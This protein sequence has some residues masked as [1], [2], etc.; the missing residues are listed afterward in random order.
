MALSLVALMP[1]LQFFQG[2]RRTVRH[3]K[4]YGQRGPFFE[5][6]SLVSRVPFHRRFGATRS[7]S[8]T[9]VDHTR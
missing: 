3:R 4:T 1:R 2:L 5:P 6:D 7:K 9:L 8:V